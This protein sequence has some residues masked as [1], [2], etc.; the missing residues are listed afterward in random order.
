VISSGETRRLH[1]REPN[2]PH[3]Q[4]TDPNA[5]PGN[6]IGTTV[7]HSPDARGLRIRLN[8]VVSLGVAVFAALFV[9]VTVGHQVIDSL[10][11]R[12][13][14]SRSVHRDRSTFAGP[15]RPS[16]P[17]TLQIA[18]R[19]AEGQTIEILVEEAAYARFVVESHAY[20]RD[21]QR[22]A[23]AEL[24]ELVTH[25]LQPIEARTQ[26][27]V[28][29]YANWYFAW[30]TSYQLMLEAAKSLIQH[31]PAVE[32][33]SLKD[34]VSHDVGTYIQRHYEEIVLYPEATD[35]DIRRAFEAAYEAAQENYRA[36][37]A[38]L[39][40]RFQAFVLEHAP[41]ARPL[42]RG[43]IARKVEIDWQSHSHKLRLARL[44]KGSA[45]DASRGALVVAGAVVGA[46]VGGGVAGSVAARAAGGRVAASAARQLAVRSAAPFA[47]RAA[48][49]TTGAV[50]GSAMGGPVGFAVGG[51]VALLADYLIS[52]GV[53]MA[54]RDAFEAEAR[55]TVN[56]TYREMAQA[57]TDSLVQ[58]TN[59]W[60]DDTVQLLAPFGEPMTAGAG[61]TAVP[62]PSTANGPPTGF[63]TIGNETSFS[64]SGRE[65]HNIVEPPIP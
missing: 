30:G 32:V 44:D 15:A 45:L 34:M 20:L 11:V 25:Q 17:R 18:Y 24:P 57:M 41:H 62:A 61:L 13:E 58:H 56:V 1:V 2:V 53:E 28:E 27:R 5:T 31:A 43:E 52:K 36:A 3:L 40:T 23:Q 35:P 65:P 55:E 14:Q 63:V 22:A 47:S 21:R 49:M 6:E 7:G 37:L 38:E 48:S 39:D 26:E 59:V 10:L 12:F 9:L 16:V 60:F 33:A 29:D 8:K 42:V 4:P 46:R 51:G 64:R 50:G 54:Q 19:N